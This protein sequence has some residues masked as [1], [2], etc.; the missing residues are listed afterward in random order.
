MKWIAFL[1]STLHSSMLVRHH[2]P[3]NILIGRNIT[4][5]FLKD[6][7][8][9]I[10]VTNPTLEN[11]Y[12]DK[13]SAWGSRIVVPDG[14]NYKTLHTVESIIQDA[15]ALGCDKDSCLI[16]LGGGVIGDLTGLSANLYM[17]GIRFASVPTTLMSMVDSSIGGKNGVNTRSA[18]NMLGTFYNPQRICIDLDFLDTLPDREFRSGL[19]EIIKCAIIWDASFF[20]WLEQNMEKLRARHDSALFFAIERTCRIK[21]D[22]VHADPYDLLGLRALL[23]LG[24]TFGHAIETRTGYGTFLHGEAVSIGIE[25]ASRLAFWEGHLHPTHYQRIRKLLERA[26]LPVHYKISGRDMI[27]TMK[28]DKKNRQQVIRLILPIKIGEAILTEKF[29]PRHLENCCES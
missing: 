18:K 7:P 4:D 1:H 21:M 9:S 27:E 8:G 20:E 25:K 24:H 19:A 22:I 6:Y 11:L 23:N 28:L 5:S 14:E 2:T 16:A 29:S 17:R 26:G 12:R 15:T 10:I 13:F 3:Y